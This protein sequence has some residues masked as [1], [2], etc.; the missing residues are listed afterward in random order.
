MQRAE[1]GKL[2]ALITER[3]RGKQ[4]TRQLK[5]KQIKYLYRK[6]LMEINNSNGYQ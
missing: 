2:K 6:K 3:C 4:T 5:E 1:K